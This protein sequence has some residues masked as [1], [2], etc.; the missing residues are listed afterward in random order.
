M[1]NQSLADNKD[2]KTVSGVEYIVLSGYCLVG[3]ILVCLK[4]LIL[5]C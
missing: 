5:G 1:T 4:H 2:G 3:V